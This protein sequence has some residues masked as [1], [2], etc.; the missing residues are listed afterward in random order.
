MLSVCSNRG[1]VEV[2]GRESNVVIELSDKK[3]GILL[4][5][6]TGTALEK[7]MVRFFH[8]AIFLLEN[9]IWSKSCFPAGKIRFQ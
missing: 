7:A 5:I 2:G 4:G 3:H 1:F 6:A 8:T 9:T